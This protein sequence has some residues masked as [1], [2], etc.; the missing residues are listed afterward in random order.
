MDFVI[1]ISAKRKSLLKLYNTYFE[2]KTLVYSNELESDILE[3]V[4]QRISRLEYELM[5]LKS[6]HWDWLFNS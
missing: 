4:L 6:K 1:Q 3:E 5:V 2:Y